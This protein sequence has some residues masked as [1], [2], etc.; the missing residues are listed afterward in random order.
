MEGLARQ[1]GL[2]VKGDKGYSSALSSDIP[3]DSQINYSSYSEE[4]VQK[5]DQ[6]ARNTGPNRDDRRLKQKLK[7]RDP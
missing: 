7:R 5:E 4:N 3:N 6:V 1:A 2:V